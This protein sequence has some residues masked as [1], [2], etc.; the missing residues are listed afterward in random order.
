M[1]IVRFSDGSYGIRRWF[2]WPTDYEYLGDLKV[3]GKP[4]Y[5]WTFEPE[6]TCKFSS[7]EAALNHWNNYLQFKNTP[8]YKDYGD[9]C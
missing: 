5:W 8:K 1:K 9:P 7:K 6:E 4:F 3:N 2:V